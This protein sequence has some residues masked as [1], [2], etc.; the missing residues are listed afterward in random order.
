MSESLQSN[1]LDL[2]FIFLHFDFFDSIR[3]S[4]CIKLTFNLRKRIF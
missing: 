3:L 4:L 2:I 1:I